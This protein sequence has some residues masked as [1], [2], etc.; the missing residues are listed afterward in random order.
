MSSSGWELVTKNKKDKNSGKSNKLTKVEKKKFIENAPKVE[1]FLPLSQVQTLYDNFNGNKENKM[2]KDKDNKTK[3]NEE[4]KK[5]QKLNVQADG[6]KKIQQQK[7]KEKSKPVE[8]S[9]I[10]VDQINEL[11]ETN[12]V[13]FPDAPLIWLK[14]LVSYLNANISEKEEITPATKPDTYPL[15]LVTKAVRSSFE[16]VIKSAGIQTAQLFYENT[17]LLMAKNMAFGSSDIGCKIFIQLLGNMYPDMTCSN[18]E[19]LTSL[20]NS[21][22]NKKSIGLAILWALSQG[23]KKNLT[24]GLTLWHEVMASMLE[25]RNYAYHVTK[26]L[27]EL[28]NIHSKNISN[29]LTADMYLNIVDDFCSGKINIHASLSKE[30]SNCLQLLRDTIIHSDK[31]DVKSLFEH[32]IDRINTKTNPLHKEEL[33]RILALCIA[34]DNRSLSLWNKIHLKRLYQSE[35]LI[36]QL[37]DDWESIRSDVDAKLLKE[38]L[39]V[40]QIVEVKPKKNKEDLLMLACQKKSEDLIKKMS[41]SAKKSRSFP[42]KKGSFILLILIGAVVAFDCRKHGSFEASATG[43]LM[44]TTGVIGYGQN[45]WST[46]KSY[47]NQGLAYLEASFP[48]YYKTASTY[49][50]QYAKLAG[51]FYIVGRNLAFKLYNNTAE[52]VDKKKPIVVDSIEQYFPGWLDTIQKFGAKQFE[53]TKKYSADASDFIVKQSTTFIR[54]LET[55]VFVGK[56]SPENIRGYATEAVKSTQAFASQT[57]DWV[58]EKVQTLSK[59]Q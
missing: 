9:A 24:V 44:R 16:K 43:R 13:K 55:S 33:L 5:Q 6:K 8:K 19:K 47:S 39:G 37:T 58:Y 40:F 17:L 32:T 21:Y 48:D 3:E 50:Q 27:K 10:T 29:N 22:Q 59:V 12:R 54:W 30:I 52:F 46:T 42:W 38:T 15:S 36:K 11:I 28:F 56:M 1:D 23:G 4:K 35:L 26:I 7:P 53:L 34:K 49:G 2:P 31:I 25:S 51:D 14:D 20:R 45:A 41:A 18:I 57:Y